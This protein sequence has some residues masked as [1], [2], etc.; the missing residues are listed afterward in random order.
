LDLITR[1]GKAFEKRREPMTQC[2]VLQSS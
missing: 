2:G 1:N